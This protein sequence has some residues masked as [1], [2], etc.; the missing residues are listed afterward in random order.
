MY[1]EG[2]EALIHYDGFKAWYFS[3]GSFRVQI[4]REER[5]WVNLFGTCIA[6]EH[7]RKLELETDFEVIAERGFETSHT[8]CQ[9]PRTEYRFEIS[10]KECGT[11]NR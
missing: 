2:S 9:P 5:G 6:Q 8:R 1:L 7:P 10:T 11:L 4:V 3:V